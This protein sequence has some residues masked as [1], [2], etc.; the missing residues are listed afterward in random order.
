MAAGAGFEPAEHLP[1]LQVIVPLLGA[2]ACAI[3]RQRHACWLIALACSLAMPAIAFGL[4]AEVEQSGPI[5][6][7]LGGFAPPLGIEYRIESLSIHQLHDQERVTACRPAEIEDSH[8]R[9][10]PETRCCLRLAR[11]S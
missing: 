5:S 11:H 6:H 3:V 2:V 9:R 4:L 7:A 1:A 10:V 8:H